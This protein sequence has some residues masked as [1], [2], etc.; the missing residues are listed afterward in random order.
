MILV[1]LSSLANFH[2]EKE[3]FDYMNGDYLAIN[4]WDKVEWDKVNFNNKEVYNIPKFYKNL[5]ASYYGR[6]D[7]KAVDYVLIDHAK[8][9]GNKY[10]NDLGCNGCALD[11]GNQLIL[12][13]EER[14]THPNGEFISI[15]GNYPKGSMMKATEKGFV[16]T[17]PEGIDKLIMPSTD[18][19]TLEVKSKQLTV[20]AGESK[21]AVNG[22][23][24]Y[25]NGEFVIGQQDLIMHVLSD[26]AAFKIGDIQLIYKNGMF[27]PI[28]GFLSGA[29]KQLGTTYIIGRNADVIRI[30]A[31][32]EYTKID[33]I[34]G[35]VNII[36]YVK[37]VS[38]KIESK[39]PFVFINAGDISIEENEYFGIVSREEFERAKNKK[40][41]L[42]KIVEDYKRERSAYTR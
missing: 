42:Y 33:E 10:L 1:S 32:E 23:I 17:L 11:K 19:A 20:T 21:V 13:S 37:P 5:P 6:L 2:G 18:S 15:P 28:E 24:G 14:V 36:F 3:N 26:D 4:D 12:F 29:S 38:K 41:L 22:D 16:I 34:K 40:T 27:L 35:K 7:Y 31:A 8:V 39:F 30:T 9:D 25:K